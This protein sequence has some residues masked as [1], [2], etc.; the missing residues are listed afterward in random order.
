MK[1][2][3]KPEPPFNFD[4][5]ASLY[6]R[7]PVQ[8]VDLYSKGAYERVLRDKDKLFLVRIKSVGTIEKPK[9]KVGVFPKGARKKFIKD[10][11][12]WILGTDDELKGFYKIA[13]KDEKFSKLIEG[14]YGLRAPRAA[15]V[16]EA[17]ITALIEQQISFRVSVSLKKN[18]VEKYGETLKIKSKKYYA[19]PEPEALARAK[20]AEIRKVGLSIRKGEYMIGVSQKVI[21]QEFDLEKMKTWKQ[22]KILEALTKIRGI[23][24]WTVEYMMCRGMGRY[25]ALPADDIGLRISLTNFLNEKKRVSEKKARKF[26]DHFGRYRGYAGFYLIYAYAFQKYPQERLL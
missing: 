22:E 17:L 8:C 18:L 7:F 24:P 9:L 4:L 1:F 20:Q 26:L 6:S 21:E 13:Q 2:F 23:G 12:K 19:F 10:K 11:V 15:T 25:E 3:V 14:L 5:I 16:F